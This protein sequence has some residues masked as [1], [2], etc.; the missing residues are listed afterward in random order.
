[1]HNII[2]KLKSYQTPLKRSVIA[3]AGCALAVCLAMVLAISPIG[4]NDK[5]MAASAPVAIDMINYGSNTSS[6]TAAIIAAH[7]EFLIDNSPAGPW[8]GDANI[9]EYMAAG[10]KYFE[11]LDGGY[12]GTQARSIPN[13][14][15]SNLSY[16][17]AA[18]K[19]GA[20]GIFL[21]EV[22][23]NPNA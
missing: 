11:Y 3:I 19:D 15:A 7:P 17:T 5:V 9:S 13:D 8:K 20:Y 4:G 2:G 23:S 18:A 1:M 16:I 21:D 12:E 10:I 14:L 22:S 6:V